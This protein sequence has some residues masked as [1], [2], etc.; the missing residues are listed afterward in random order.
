MAEARRK[1]REVFGY[2]M[3]AT[4]DAPV[5]EKDTLTKTNKVTG[6]R[7]VDGNSEVYFL[8]NKMETDK[9]RVRLGKNRNDND[10]RGFLMVVLSLILLSVSSVCFKQ[11]IAF[12]SYYLGWNFTRGSTHPY[13][14]PLF[15]YESWSGSQKS[16]H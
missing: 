2:E 4:S 6:N 11:R 16:I 14:R 12:T 15:R 13:S 8:I 10:E 7:T 3:V 5:L 1:F 9:E